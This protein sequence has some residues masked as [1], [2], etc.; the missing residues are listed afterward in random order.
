MPKQQRESVYSES[1]YSRSSWASSITPSFIDKFPKPPGEGKGVP[2][3]PA[4]D[5]R[6]LASIAE[7]QSG[8]TRHEQLRVPTATAAQR[9]R[10]SSFGGLSGEEKSALK[11]APIV[12]PQHLVP[13]SHPN[14]SKT[15]PVSIQRKPAPAEEPV[16]HGQ[17]R[18][19]VR[20]AE[21]HSSTSPHTP[22]KL[23]KNRPRPS[24][25][26]PLMSTLAPS[27][28]K[29]PNNAEL[30]PSRSKTPNNAALAPSRPKTPNN[31]AMA[32]SRPKTPNNAAPSAGIQFASPTGASKPSSRFVTSP[33]VIRSGPMFP[34]NVHDGSYLKHREV[35]Y[36]T[37]QERLRNISLT[38]AGYDP[39]TAPRG[40]QVHIGMFSST[41]SDSSLIE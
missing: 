15:R 12:R 16:L 2:P 32:P 14:S 33:S 24:H 7:E 37:T 41:C 38:N 27:R 26:E 25:P 34:T 36:A 40:G 9:R 20:E 18:R 22:S 35:R 11:H 30:A 19:H 13:P 29:T 4:L 3:V 1:V 31:A 28:P 10:S 8:A 6:T 23:T 39:R 21:H 5:A 17:M